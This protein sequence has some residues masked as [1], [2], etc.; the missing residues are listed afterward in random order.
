MALGALG[1]GGELDVLPC[2]VQSLSEETGLKHTAH[3][4]S[5]VPVCSVV[6]DSDTATQ[7]RVEAP[8]AFIIWPYMAGHFLHGAFSTP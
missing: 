8:G 1:N 6:P 2:V 4:D 5:A 3:E 7:P